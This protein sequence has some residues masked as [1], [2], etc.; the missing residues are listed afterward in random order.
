MT[1]TKTKITYELKNRLSELVRYIK[2]DT[3]YT[4]QEKIAKKIG[5]PHTN[6]SSALRGNE[7]Y[8]TNGTVNSFCSAFPK[9]SKEWL[10][11][12]KGNMLIGDTTVGDNNNIQ[13][14][15][16]NNI[17]SHNNTSTTIEK[18]YINKK[19]FDFEKFTMIANDFPALGVT[20]KDGRIKVVSRDFEKQT[21]YSIY[22]CIGKTFA[23]VL[24]RD[25]FPK[26]ETSRL[27]VLLKSGEYFHAEMKPYYHKN[28]TKLLCD[29][30]IFPFDEGFVSAANFLEIE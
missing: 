22:D 13:K 27:R 15:D 8:L 9:I 24:Q 12:G 26:A 11:T 4:T 7:K 10:L 6:L 2:F 17:N 20:D 16:N 1:T 30:H 18:Q 29:I 21:G 25:D 19:D 3:E 5:M 14:G 23:E 28:G